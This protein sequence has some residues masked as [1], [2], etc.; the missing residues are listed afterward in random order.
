MQIISINY[1]VDSAPESA[2]S[3]LDVLQ[4]KLRSTAAL[5]QTLYSSALDDCRVCMQKR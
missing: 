3:G 2:A 4:L 1:S 5:P